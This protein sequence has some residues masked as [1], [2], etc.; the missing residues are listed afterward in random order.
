MNAISFLSGFVLGIAIVT[1]YTAVIAHLL[2]RSPGETS[3]GCDTKLSEDLRK[4][5]ASP[6]EIVAAVRGSNPLEGDF[7]RVNKVEEIL[8]ERQGGVVPLQEVL[9]D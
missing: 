6:E 7:I 4:S 1:V 2:R 3:C 8:R 5:S 9:E